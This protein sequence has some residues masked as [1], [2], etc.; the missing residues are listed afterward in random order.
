MCVVCVCVCVRLYIDNGIFLIIMKES[1]DIFC[2]VL[3]THS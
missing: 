1:S 2:D 3:D